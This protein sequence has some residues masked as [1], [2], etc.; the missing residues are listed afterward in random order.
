MKRTPAKEG[1]YTNEQM[2]FADYLMSEAWSSSDI[3]SLDEEREG[4]PALLKY[5][6]ENPED[7]DKDHFLVGRSLHSLVLE[8]RTPWVV[9]PETYTNEKLEIKPWNNNA[10]VC[11]AFHSEHKA[12]GVDVLS[13]KQDGDVR[14]WAEAIL[15][16]PAA[17]RLLSQ[18]GYSEVTCI[19]QDPE[20]GLW[21][22]VR[23]DFL[24]TDAPFMADIKTALDVSP[25]GFGSSAASLRYEGQA[26]LYLHAFNLLAEKNGLAKK[27]DWLHVAVR[28][29]KPHFVRCYFMEQSQILYGGECMRKWMRQL[30]TCIEN[31]SWPEYAGG[32]EVSP[33]KY[34]DWWNRKLDRMGAV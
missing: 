20:T 26:W 29:P 34:P 17:E 18:K 31:N 25:H 19:V 15:K 8:N 5:N 28:K 1:I 7:A 6:R 14:A 30:A 21:L 23:I 22:R 12:N 11:R 2:P 3:R 32:E 16:N 24:P 33:L 4:C 27:T 10:K 13:A 9:Q